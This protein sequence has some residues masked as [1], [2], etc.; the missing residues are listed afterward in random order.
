MLVYQNLGAI[1]KHL[2]I[3][4]HLK[5]EETLKVVQKSDHSWNP[6]SF[7]D[8]KHFVCSTC[9]K[10]VF[11]AN[12]DA[13]TTK[14]LKEVNSRAKIQPNK[15][16]NNNKL[17]DPTSHTQ[18]PSR[19]IVTGHSF[20]PISLPL[21]MRKQTLLDLSL[22]LHISQ[23]PRGIFLNQ[24]KYAIES[25]IKYGMESCDLVDTLMVKKYKLD[26]DPQRKSVDLTK[27]SWHGGHPYVSHI[28]STGPGTVTRGLWYSKDSAIALTAFTDADHVGCQDTKQS[29]SGSM[30]LLGDTLVS[31]LSK[32]QKSVAF[33]SMGAE[34]ISLSG[35]CAQV[36][37]MRS[38]L[39][40]FGLVFN[41][42][43]MYC[44]NKSAITL[45]CN[46]VQHSRSKHIEIRYH[47]I[48]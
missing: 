44:D 39:T 3:G 42:I 15:T 47:F 33:S 18:K 46:N 1:I 25:L 13:C 22:G 32:R 43:P 23:S 4:L 24:S 12:H 37:W 16:R 21:C 38:Q 6:S 29:T 17:V 35:C 2:G 8:F 7:L 34:Y 26:E 27:L 5:V 14:I 41:K 11:N 36:L 48:K 20:L 19:K 31:W 10:C 40:D 9:Q 28:Q 45:C 30:Q